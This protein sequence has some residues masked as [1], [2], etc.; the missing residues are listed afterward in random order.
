M[1]LDITKDELPK[2][3]VCIVRCVLH[4]SNKM[5]NNFLQQ[6]EGKFNTY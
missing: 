6:I 2:A 3:D 1:V 4:L 5:I